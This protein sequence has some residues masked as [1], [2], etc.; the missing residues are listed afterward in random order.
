MK[1]F[2]RPKKSVV[3][4]PQPLGPRNEIF[5]EENYRL[6]SNNRVCV[7]AAYR[8]NLSEP[9][10]PELFENQLKVRPTADSRPTRRGRRD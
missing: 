6:N 7:S 3:E 2:W 10:P 4:H 5:G 9:E 8:V 1:N